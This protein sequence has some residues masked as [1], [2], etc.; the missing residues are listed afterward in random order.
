MGEIFFKRLFL[1]FLLV[2]SSF[3]MIYAIRSNGIVSGDVSKN[4]VASSSG[5]RNL[6]SGYATHPLYS[7][8]SSAS[9]GF[10]FDNVSNIVSAGDSAVYNVGYFSV[11]GSAWQ[12]FTLTGAFYPSSAFWLGG[13]ATATLPS[14]GIG[15]HYV[16]VYSCTYN[17][18]NSSWDC[19]ENKWQLIIVNITA[20]NII[21]LIMAQSIILLPAIP[22]A[23]IVLANRMSIAL[24]MFAC[25]MFLDIHISSRQ[26]VMIIILEHI[27]SPGELGR[28]HSI[29]QMQET[30]YILEKACGILQYL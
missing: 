28:K 27:R 12:N 8:F 6:I 4:S 5:S 18:S 14:F 13:S 9:S 7:S 15:E 10:S 29:L 30:L 2:V 22:P 20:N 3:F 26:M 17:S 24:R 11:N 1:L 19:H 21:I 23:E 25:L 16:I